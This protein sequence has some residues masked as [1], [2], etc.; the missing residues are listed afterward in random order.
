MSKKAYYISTALLIVLLSSFL[1]FET[2]LKRPLWWDEIHDLK[3]LNQI[4]DFSSIMKMGSQ[5]DYV[6]P[7]L[8]DLIVYQFS[9]FNNNRVQI[10]L[11][12]VLFGIGSIII[13][14][15]F[16]RMMFNTKTG[17]IAGLLMGVSV[18]H[19]NYSQDGRHYM[20]VMTFVLL[21]YYF[22]FSYYKSS[23]MKDL[24]LYVLASLCAIY[25]HHTGLISFGTTVLMSGIGRIKTWKNQTFSKKDIYFLVAL[26]VIFLF[27]IPQLVLTWKYFRSD[28]MEPNWVLWP[29]IRF[30]HELFGRW[31]SS[32]YFTHYLYELFF[33]LGVVHVIRKRDL[34]IGLLVWFI[35]PIVFFLIVPFDKF[36]DIRYLIVSLPAFFLILANGL[37]VF[38]D[39]IQSQFNAIC[40]KMALSKKIAPLIIVLILAIF[41]TSAF[42]TYLTFRQTKIRCSE[43]FQ[44]T[45]ILNDNNGFC[46]DRI[47]LNSLIPEDKYILLSIENLRNGIY[48]FFRPV[49]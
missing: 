6:Y 12:S 15:L 37:T 19:I 41:I 43:F 11:P 49:L 4:E 22:F 33:L 25:S 45:K 17:L 42:S 32:V 30:F 26:I 36:F 2:F 8:H 7:P 23:R 9:Q 18:Y 46:R 48:D 29:S 38:V 28:I 39:Y 21:M 40:P 3:R 5:D 35:S 13:M 10:R 31:T 27:Y 16:G 47:I 44:S 14:I 34:S 20:M 24:I 1:R